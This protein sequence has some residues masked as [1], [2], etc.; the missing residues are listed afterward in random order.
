[1]KDHGAYL[2]GS[3]A[4]LNGGVVELNG[5]HEGKSAVANGVDVAS[6]RDEVGE[7]IRAW[8]EGR[9]GATLEG[10]VGRGGREEGRKGES[11]G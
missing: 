4:A 11:R 1:M 3:S 9:L 2:A 8:W 7:G 10:L 5:S 6:R